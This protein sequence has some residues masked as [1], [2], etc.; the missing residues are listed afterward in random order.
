[1][2]QF[3]IVFGVA[4]LLALI[5]CIAAPILFV[6]GQTN[7]D[8]FKGAFLG[9]TVAWFVCGWLWTREDRDP[10]KDAR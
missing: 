9:G 6:A 7:E 4:A 2:K 1:M 3:R 10:A 5:A 8:G